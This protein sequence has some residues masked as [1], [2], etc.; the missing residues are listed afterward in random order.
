PAGARVAVTPA[1]LEDLDASRAM[2]RS[3]AEQLGALDVL[4]N[5]AA[6]RETLS[7]RVLSPESWDRTLRI[8]LTTPAY[9]ARDAAERMA[10]PAGKGGVILNVSSIYA[11]HSSGLASAYTAAKAGI[12]AVTRDLACAYSG[13]GVRAVALRLG[14]I[15]TEMSRDY[16][17]GP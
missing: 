6:W 15:D 11:V 12:E 16:T 10:Q 13:R 1:D 5:N 17:D 4:V 7:L 8:S 3:L 2:L 14:A 9:L